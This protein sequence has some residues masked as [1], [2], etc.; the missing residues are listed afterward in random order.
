MLNKTIA[1][2]VSVSVLSAAS[3]AAPLFNEFEPNP[4]GIDPATQTIEI[5]GT[6]GDAFSGWVISIES[7]AVS[8]R[9][10][11]DRAE[12]VSGSFNSDGL[13]TVDIADLENPSFT[14]VLVD[15]FTGSVGS[16]DVD[17]DDDG[18]VDDVSSFGN[19][20]DALDVTD[21]D[22][23]DE[24]HYGVDLGGVNFAYI[25]SEPV[26]MFRDGTTQAWYAVDFNGDAYDEAGNLLD[27]AG[28]DADASVLTYGAANPSLS[29]QSAVAVPMSTPLSLL[30][31]ALGLAFIARRFGKQA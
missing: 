31:G 23:E 9:G 14:L 21:T 19:V 6:P 13:L 2:F 27:A 30:I 24:P 10:T 4:A 26:N 29:T 18:V 16:S 15:N 3:S 8:A 28:F 12:Q 25:G 11:V 20:Y 17:S 22:S 1:A 7:D 5:L